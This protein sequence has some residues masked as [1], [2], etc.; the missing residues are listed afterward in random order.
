MVLDACECV[1]PGTP[2]PRFGGAG[3]CLLT[4]WAE[5]FI[6]FLIRELTRLF[7][8]KRTGRTGWNQLECKRCNYTVFLQRLVIKHIDPQLC[9]LLALKKNNVV[10]AK[11]NY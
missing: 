2:L 1:R 7:A 8:L 5:V 10:N 6:E 11:I 3:R 9:Y 4:A